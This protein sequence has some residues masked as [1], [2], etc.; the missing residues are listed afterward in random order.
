MSRHQ[1]HER[2]RLRHVAEVHRRLVDGRA[3]AK[4]GADV[5]AALFESLRRADKVA[6]AELPDE[7]VEGEGGSLLHVPQRHTLPH[8]LPHSLAQQVCLRHLSHLSTLLGRSYR[9]Q[10]AH[11]LRSRKVGAGR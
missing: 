2:H 11:A 8:A 6:G 3:D 7:A 9:L 4:A 1:L 5:Q 10:G